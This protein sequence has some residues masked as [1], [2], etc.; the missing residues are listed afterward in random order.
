MDRLS[1]SVI[2]FLK[3]FQDDR[4]EKIN[5]RSLQHLFIYQGFFSNLRLSNDDEEEEGNVV[6]MLC[7]EPSRPAEVT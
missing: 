1:I 7:N 6:L 2:Y 4:N 5:L 3:T